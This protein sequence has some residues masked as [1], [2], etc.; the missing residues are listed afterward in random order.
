MVP[1][2]QSKTVKLAIGQASVGVVGILTYLAVVL[3]NPELT[4][5]IINFLKV[6]QIN[7]DP[8]LWGSILLILKSAIDYYLRSITSEPLA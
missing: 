1:K 4:N 2:L 3:G 5:A 7:A 8:V 6:L